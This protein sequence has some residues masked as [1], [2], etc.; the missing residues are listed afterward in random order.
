MTGA[1]LEN[2]LGGTLNEMIFGDSVAW[3]VFLFARPISRPLSTVSETSKDSHEEIDWS[4][5][6]GPRTLTLPA[7]LHYAIFN[8]L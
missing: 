6:L 2:F 3:I 5:H 4:S 1:I 8:F 7:E